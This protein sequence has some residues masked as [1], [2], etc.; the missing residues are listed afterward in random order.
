[1]FDSQRLRDPGKIATEL[2]ETAQSLRSERVS[3]RIFNA[4]DVFFSYSCFLTQSRL[5][6]MIY[7]RCCISGFQGCSH[8]HLGV[9]IV[10]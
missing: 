5:D 1:M 9:S 2:L 3:V 8:L 7:I 4:K 6:R 10:V